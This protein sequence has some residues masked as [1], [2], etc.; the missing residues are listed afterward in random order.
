MSMLLLLNYMGIS[1][2]TLKLVFYGVYEFVLHIFFNNTISFI[3][4]T[5]MCV[6]DISSFF[7]LFFVLFQSYFFSH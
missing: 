2:I 7:S 1:Q 6:S 5:L 4:G 3:I